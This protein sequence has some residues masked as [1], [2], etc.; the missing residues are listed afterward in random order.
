MHPYEIL[1]SNSLSGV[2]RYIDNVAIHHT[3]EVV[4]ALNATGALIFFLPPYSPDYMPCEELFSQTKKFIRA[5][6][7]AWQNCLDPELMV[8]ESFLHVT[9]D[10]IK[11][12]I[13]HADYL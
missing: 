10:Q 5:N 6:D 1:I 12:Y 3:Q 13:R 2:I 7:I 11:N 9:D 4:D 8:Y